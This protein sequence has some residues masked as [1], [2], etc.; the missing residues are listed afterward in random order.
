M[1]GDFPTS[2]AITTLPLPHRE[3]EVRADMLRRFETVDVANLGTKSKGRE[4]TYAGNGSKQ[5]NDGIVLRDILHPFLD[6]F[7]VS[8]EFSELIEQKIVHALGSIRPHGNLSG[9]GIGTILP[10]NGLQLILDA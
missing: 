3:A 9:V 10:I 6:A 1:L 7:D 5:W 4:R 8:I 2:F